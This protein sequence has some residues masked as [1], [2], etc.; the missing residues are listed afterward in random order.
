MASFRSLI[1]NAVS[2]I[3]ERAINHVRRR[4]ATGVRVTS[5]TLRFEPA[6]TDYVIH[7]LY[8]LTTDLPGDRRPIAID[9]TGGSLTPF[10]LHLGWAG[11]NAVV[12]TLPVHAIDLPAQ[13]ESWSGGVVHASFRWDPLRRPWSGGDGG[14]VLVLPDALPRLLEPAGRQSRSVIPQPRLTIAEPLPIELGVAG[15]YAPP[16]LQW[17]RELD[18]SKPGFSSVVIGGRRT[19]RADA[20]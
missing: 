12:P 10:D 11:T 9:C 13:Q 15:F 3:A 14:P 19:M 18:T 8:E 2:G 16:V 1:G 5:I 7:A 17:R 4:I 6:K 20:G